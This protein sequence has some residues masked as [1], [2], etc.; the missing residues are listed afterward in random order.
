MA[1]DQLSFIVA[2][3]SRFTNE[4]VLGL[5][6]EVNANLREDTPRDTG[7]ARANWMPSIG[8]PFLDTF[9]SSVRDP[10]P[11]QVTGQQARQQAAEAKLLRYDIEMGAIFTTNNVPYINR[12]NEGWSAQA[13][14]A[15]VQR[16]V[17]R[18]L[19]ERE[20]LAP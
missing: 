19:M 9:A 1:E 10:T 3:L 8:A 6:L 15:F 16:A 4:E 2:D 7:W 5:A 12:L 20:A 14:T 18:A 17:G 13:G 11:A